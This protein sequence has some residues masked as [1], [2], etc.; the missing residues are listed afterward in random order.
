MILARRIR[1]KTADKKKGVAVMMSLEL[2]NRMCDE[3]ELKQTPA[4]SQRGEL[5][6]KKYF[7]YRFR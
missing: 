1:G 7:R 2:G 6:P 3:E 4:L 5:D